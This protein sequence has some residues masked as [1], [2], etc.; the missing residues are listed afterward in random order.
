M[1]FFSTTKGKILAFI[2]LASIAVSIILL[3]YNPSLRNIAL[4]NGGSNTNNSNSSP[5]SLTKSTPTT[6]DVLPVTGKYL[7]PKG[8]YIDGE[9]TGS[10]VSST[11]VLG[12]DVVIKNGVMESIKLV[13]VPN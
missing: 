4:P 12:I 11:G 1:E 7:S 9:Y 10:A 2:L 5:L 6:N 13:T 8:A 3:I